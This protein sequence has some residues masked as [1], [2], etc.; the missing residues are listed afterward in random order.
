MQTTFHYTV[1]PKLPLIRRSGALLPMGKN[2]GDNELPMLWFSSRHDFE[3]TAIKPLMSNRGLIRPS[4]QQLHEFVGCYRFR[5]NLELLSFAQ[6]CKFA[7]TPSKY[8]QLM[9]SNGAEWGADPEHWFATDKPVI[10]KALGFERWNGA[11]WIQANFNDEAT[12]VASTGQRVL[13]M[14]A[15]A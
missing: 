5:A 9:L 10:L 6:A 3:P 13:M 2:L 14:S 4:F 11:N 12:K 7:K 8:I 1:G 15:V